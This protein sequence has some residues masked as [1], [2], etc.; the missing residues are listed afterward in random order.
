MAELTEYLEVFIEEMEEQLQEMEKEILGLE[1]GGNSATGVQ[2]LFRAAHTLKGSSAAM[3]IEPVHQLTHEMEFVLDKVRSKQLDVT[4]ALI[5]LLF[6]CLDHLQQL[7]QEYLSGEGIST[8]ISSLVREM[9]TLESAGPK[10]E[11]VISEP[12]S[13]ADISAR[14]AEAERQGLH[15]YLVHIQLAPE[16]M[17]KAARAVVIEQNMAEK[18]KVLQV[19]PSLQGNDPEDAQFERLQI[20]WATSLEIPEVQEYILASADV[21]TVHVED[22]S[23]EAT[24]K[25]KENLQPI[26]N[27]QKTQS[28]IRVNVDRLEHLM[29]LVGELVIHQTRIHQVEH[30]L[31]QR[32][33]DEAVEELE[34]ITDQV[35]R[36]IGD[37]QESVMKIRMLPIEQ[38]FNRFPRMVRDLSQTL[39]KEVELVIEGKE[40]EL[41]R[42]LIEEISDPLIHL[43]RNAVDHGIEAPETRSKLGKHP[44]GLL[45]IQAAHEENQVVIT[46]ED[47]GKG[48]DPHKLKSSAL[49]KGIIGDEEAAGLTD[50]QAIQLIFRPGF[51]TASA[52]TEVSGRGVGMD[53]VKNHIEKLN[54]MI[55]I[56]TELGKGTRFKIKL[57]LTLAII[58]G[59]LVKLNEQTF[60][61]PMSNV[62]EIVRIPQEQIETIK[63]QT[64]VVIRNQVI[65]LVW[66][67]DSFNIP[68]P[69][70]QRK[71]LPVV[72]V[73]IAEKRLALMVDELI[74][75]QE[76]VIKSLG[77]YLGKVNGILGGTILGDGRV[78]MILEV[79]GILKMV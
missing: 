23:S 67:H 16:C 41:D 77:S 71:M 75:N 7:K 37:L 5:N 1:A 15:V 28:S 52:V 73:G 48:L 46:I 54:G 68:R 2:A 79:S 69:E 62:A 50:Q 17:M 55:D 13:D 22:Y 24:S 9:K 29:N 18:G 8:D 61:L 10:S 74:G 78:A 19:F 14:A 76:I 42:T 51:S 58:T 65:P 26:V 44:R 49:A 36:V 27:S 64:V 63:G 11:E 33:G 56:E 21:E 60:I 30:L 70:K 59:L 57:P 40:T 47:D 31:S 20:V 35:S 6:S 32:Y 66:L 38:L 34:G 43:I 25:E 45:K 39:H 4:P 12:V 53:I 3:G 72:I